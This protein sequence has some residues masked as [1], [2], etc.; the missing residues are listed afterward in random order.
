MYILVGNEANTLMQYC[1]TL[2]LKKVENGEYVL[3]TESDF[4]YYHD[5]E[6]RCLFPKEFTLVYEIDSIPENVECGKYCYTEADGFYKNSNYQEPPRTELD[7]DKSLAIVEQK[8][9]ESELGIDL[10]LSML[11]LGLA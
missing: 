4:E 9:V 8:Q 3:A 5:M 6:H 11:E 1:N 7:L 10:R 2:E